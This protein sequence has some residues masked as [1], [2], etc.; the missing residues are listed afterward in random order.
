MILFTFLPWSWWSLSFVVVWLVAACFHEKCLVTFHHLVFELFTPIFYSFPIVS[1]SLLERSM[2]GN[3]FSF[4]FLNGWWWWS[5]IFFSSGIF[6]L[7]MYCVW[8]YCLIRWPIPWKT[9]WSSWILYWLLGW[10]KRVICTNIPVVC[11]V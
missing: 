5:H 3:S 11:I 6:I 7:N 10:Q 9:S 8:Y 1:Q 2:L 4:F